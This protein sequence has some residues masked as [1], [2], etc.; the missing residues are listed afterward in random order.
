MDIRATN[1]TVKIFGEGLTEWYYFDKLRS[2]KIVFF[3][4]QPGLPGQ[5]QEQLQEAP[6]AD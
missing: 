1:F 3:H 5:K 4:S 6:A 2:K